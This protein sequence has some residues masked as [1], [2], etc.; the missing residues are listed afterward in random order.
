MDHLFAVRHG[1]YDDK[2]HL[3]NEGKEKVLELACQIHDIL[4]DSA[5]HAHILSSPAP[6][7]LETASIIALELDSDN[8]SA[9]DYL[10]TG[11]GAPAH[12]YVADGSKPKKLGEIVKN[13]IQ[14]PSLII[15]SHHEVVGDLAKHYTKLDFRKVPTAHAVHID[16]TKRPKQYKLIPNR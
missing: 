7:A 2:Y 5:S 11:P 3:S 9:L 6:R 14:A 13:R 4:G 1:P 16:F 8:L 10:W 12:N 15:V